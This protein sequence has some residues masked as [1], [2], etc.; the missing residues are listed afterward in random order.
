MTRTGKMRMPGG[1]RFYWWVAG[2]L[3]LAPLV[4]MQVTDEVH[5]T[6]FDF[7]A[8]AMLLAGPIVAYEIVSRFVTNRTSRALIGGTLTIFAL[9]VWAAGAVGIG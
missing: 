5:W 9:F 1:R 8:A 3:L 6:G 4:A 2:A 7:A